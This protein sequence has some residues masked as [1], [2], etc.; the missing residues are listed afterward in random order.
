MPVGSIGLIESRPFGLRLARS[1]AQE[2]GGTQNSID[3]RGTDSDDIGIK[4][5]VRQATIAI[6]WMFEMEPDDGVFFPVFEPVIARDRAVVLVGDAITANPFIEGGFIQADHAKQLLVA[7]LG[8]VGP[9]ID[10]VDY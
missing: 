6:E 2:V 5:H 3:G 1:A 8:S 10:E 9:V 7:S 4:H